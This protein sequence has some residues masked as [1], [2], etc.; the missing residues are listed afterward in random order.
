MPSTDL[1]S[2]LSSDVLL[3]CVFLVATALVSLKL[4]PLR[5]ISEKNGT[6][7]TAVTAYKSYEKVSKSSARKMRAAFHAELRTAGNAKWIA[8]EIEYAEKLERLERA[9]EVNAVVA[10][11]IYRLAAAKD[12]AGTGCNDT[13]VGSDAYVGAEDHAKVREALKRFVRDWCE[14]ERTESGVWRLEGEV[15]GRRVK[16]VLVP[17]AG[18]GRLAWEISQLGFDTTA[19]ERSHF[20]NL[21]FKYL[22]SAQTTR[23]TDLIPDVVPRL[24]DAFHLDEGDFF[25]TFP[26]WSYVVTLFFIDTSLNVIKTVRHI[27]SLLEPGGVWINLGPLLWTSSGVALELSL[28][29]VVRVAELV[30]FELLPVNEHGESVKMV[31]CEYTSDSEA[32]MRWLY[33]AAFWIARK[34]VCSN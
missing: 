12:E 19:N 10:S 7:L 27:Y 33:R 16:R 15:D 29:E 32:M 8:N 26:G 11:Y 2:I 3:G 22:L 18:L 31:E 23:E 30:G 21:A 24:S 5:F 25:D 1:S 9:I 4:L 17:G 20:M 14:E 28:D 6:V 34:P 13:S